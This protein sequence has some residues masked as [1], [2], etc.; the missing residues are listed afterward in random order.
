VNETEASAAAAGVE[1]ETNEQH[2][3]ILEQE[4]MIQPDTSQ[5]DEI[6]L[7]QTLDQEG[8]NSGGV[9]GDETGQD[10]SFQNETNEEDQSN[11][12]QTIDSTAN[13]NEL[14]QSIDE[15]NDQK[16]DKKDAELEAIQHKKELISKRKARNPNRFA[17]GN[18]I[19][20][21]IDE[22]VKYFDFF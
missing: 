16:D 14:T 12:D 18:L 8:A 5:L 19:P 7:D 1:E 21:E 17:D 4:D 10:A 6:T 2:E 15:T 20:E 13:E 22:E 11:L 9:V 3:A